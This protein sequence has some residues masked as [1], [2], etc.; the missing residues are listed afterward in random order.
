MKEICSECKKEMKN[1]LIE[2]K[3]LKLEALQC[4]KCKRKIFTE[5]LTM[6][7][8]SKLEA[9]RLKE[10][11]IK[12]PIKIGHSWGITFPKDIVDVFGFDNKSEIKVLPN[13]EKKII[14]L[15]L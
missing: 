2:Y 9:T 4:P 11:Y 13:I 8:I 12:K 14:E 10:E 7:V 15:K 1:A 6:K 3:G 5:E